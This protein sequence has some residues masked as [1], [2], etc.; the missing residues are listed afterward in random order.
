MMGGALGLAVLASLAA[1]RTDD[2]RDSGERARRAERRLPPR[3]HRR[4]RVR[5]RGC[6]RRRTLAPARHRGR[7]RDGSRARVAAELD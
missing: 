4:D 5:G 1:S 3:V 2:L 6:P 7:A